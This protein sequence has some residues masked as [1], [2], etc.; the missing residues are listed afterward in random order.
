MD[1]DHRFNYGQL[2]RLAFLECKR[3][4]RLAQ[5]NSVG[6]LSPAS[7]N[8]IGGNSLGDAVFIPP[9]HEHLNTLIGDLENFIHNETI[10]RHAQT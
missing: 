3:N 6:G 8:W 5:K 9:H 10:E 1:N 4:F 7:Q 2:H